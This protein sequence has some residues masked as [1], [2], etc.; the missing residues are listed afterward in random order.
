MF[1]IDSF[2]PTSGP[3]GT[4]V[5]VMVKNMPA[6][7]P[8]ASIGDTP[9][10]KPITVNQARTQVTITI[11]GN[12]KSGVIKLTVGSVSAQTSSEFTVKED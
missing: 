6:G 9:I 4:G 8:L 12:A 10:V 5:V 1:E 7:V 3:S 11:P 2:S